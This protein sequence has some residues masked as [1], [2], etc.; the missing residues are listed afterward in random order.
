MEHKRLKVLISSLVA[1]VAIQMQAEAQTLPR[2]VVCI[3][4]D[5]LRSD[6]LRELEPMMSTGGFRRMLRD[7]RVYDEVS[8]PLHPIN[9][10]SATA[11]LFTGTYPNTHGIEGTEAYRRDKGR[12]EL[13][14]ADDAYLGNYTRDNYSP[15]ALMVSTL[16]D[17]LKEASGGSALVYSVAPTAEQAI[18]SAGILADGAYWLDARIASWATT[19]YYPQMLPSLDRYNRS[20]AGPNKRLVTSGIAWKPLRSYTSPS[21]SY[22]DWSKRFNH[23]Y[24]SKD[25]LRYRESGIVNEEITNLALQ[26]LE[27]AGY[28]QRKS[29]GL[30]SLS[31]TAQPHGSEELDAE[32]V[33]TYLRL[34]AELER[35]FKA[36]DKQLGLQHC[37]ISISGTGYSNYTNYRDHKSERLRRS[38]SV[39]RLTALTNMYLTALHGPGDWISANRNGR[40]YLNHKLIESKKLN[41]SSLQ[42]EVASFLSSA[43]GLGRVVS[44]QELTTSSDDFVRRLFNA[45]HPRYKADVYWS[46][47]QGWQ[48]EDIKDNPELQARSTAIPSPFMLLGAGISPSKEPL[49]R[50]E[51]KDVVRIICSQIRIRPPND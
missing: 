26:I 4:V 36:L 37:L 16:G 6:Y 44:A 34:D 33:D 19:N 12:N 25:A 29:P 22:S 31:Y 30:L 32:D 7:G 45:S 43:E 28:A 42:T 39:A 35:L 1:L 38:L 41:L 3:S 23:R 46:V 51:V 40:L 48:V 8:F 18:S 5:Q 14:L 10:A 24:G 15:R 49:P 17:R 13:I 20:E 27:G 21:V 50:I 2:L 9:A 47:L 11:S